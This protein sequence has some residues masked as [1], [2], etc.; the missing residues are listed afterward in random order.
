VVPYST[1]LGKEHVPYFTSSEIGAQ[2][3]VPKISF[4]ALYGAQKLLFGALFYIIC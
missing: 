1:S 4:G 2:K 3:L